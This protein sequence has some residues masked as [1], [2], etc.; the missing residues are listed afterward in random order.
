MQTLAVY[1]SFQQSLSNSYWV[2]P[3]QEDV[4]GDNHL[5]AVNQ[6]LCV[7]DYCF[8]QAFIR[9]VDEV[10]CGMLKQQ[11]RLYLSF[12]HVVNFC[13]ILHIFQLQVL[14]S[15]CRLCLVNVSFK[16]EPSHRSWTSP[17]LEFFFL[18]KLQ[19]L[20]PDYF[21]KTFLDLCKVSVLSS[22]A[23]NQKY[24]VFWNAWQVVLFNCL[25][26]VFCECWNVLLSIFCWDFVP[27]CEH[28]SNIVQCLLM[29]CSF[30]LDVSQPV[31]Q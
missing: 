2:L 28:Q 14:G 30:H 17:A 3:L 23:V 15:S 4:R 29:Y 21:K 13:K 22:S 26:Q 6:P 7:S 16:F 5:E 19:F 24:F 9:E 20:C 12:S 31:T 25:E 27:V 10:S 11:E 1:F 8:T 18:S